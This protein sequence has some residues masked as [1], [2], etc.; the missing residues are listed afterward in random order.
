[1]STAAKTYWSQFGRRKASRRV[2]V[3]GMAAAGVVGL[4]GCAAPSPAPTAA[5]APESGRSIATGVPATAAPA[6]PATPTAAAAKYGGTHKQ[7]NGSADQPHLDP[8]LTNAA[9]LLAHGSG[10]AWSQLLQFKNGPGVA[11]PNFAASAD[12]AESWD[13][14]DDLTYVF[15]L[16]ADARYHN[17][18]PV[19]GRAVE[20]EDVALSFRRQIDQKINASLLAGVLR[21]EAPDKNT[22]RI[23]LDQ[24][25]PD[26]LWSLASSNCKVLPRESLSAS[27]LREGP[28]IGS[29]PFVMGTWEKTRM[30]EM[31]RNSNYFQKGRPYLDKVQWFRIGD[32]ATLLS[33]FRTKNLDVVSQGVTL[34]D[35]EQLKKENPEIVLVRT[36]SPGAWELAIKGDKPPYNDLRVRQ[37]ISKA[38]D[39]QEFIKVMFGG[40]GRLGSGL[41]T[42]SADQNL[43]TAELEQFLAYDPEGA[44]RLLQQAG[45]S[46]LEFEMQVGDFLA[47][48]VVQGAELVQAQLK[49][50]GI[51]AAL[52]VVDG[53]SWIAQVRT[54]GAYTVYFG[55]QSAPPPVN[56]D[57]RAKHHSKGT[58]LT[59]TLSDPELDALIERQST[60][61]KDAA[62]R[63]KVLQDIQRKILGLY[64]FIPLAGP[65]ENWAHWSYVKNFNQNSATNNIAGDFSWIW[66]DK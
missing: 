56:A 55:L 9:A 23:T 58:L 34:P 38:I 14:P 32:S 11:M 20:A 31:V 41:R 43:P 62:A 12:L 48:Q 8:H 61:G 13:Q 52:K 30:V 60:L 65:D 59:T 51:N 64:G 4:A 35:M 66:Y 1:M 46:A 27:D 47:G 37:A 17:I 25:N 7:S 45:V 10:M 29:G 40:V 3:G 53:T 57:L 21:I 39:R 63:T 22:V 15:K 42:A 5:V 49:K 24:P 33:A 18:A 54:G 6:A 19:N 26:I 36:P 50:V 16:R 2:V 44:R 28:V